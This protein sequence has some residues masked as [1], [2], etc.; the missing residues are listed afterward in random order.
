MNL[1]DYYT[2]LVVGI[3]V[4]ISLGYNLYTLVH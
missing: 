1:R 2:G 3:S 4:G